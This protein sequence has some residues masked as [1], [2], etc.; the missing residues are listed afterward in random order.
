MTRMRHM[1]LVAGAIAS[2][3]VL[4]VG[5]ASA[6]SIPPR[7]VEIVGNQDLGAPSGEVFYFKQGRIVVHKDDTVTWRNETVAP[8]SITIVSQNDVPHTLAQT[9]EWPLHENFLVA[10]APTIGAEGPIPPFVGSLDGFKASAASPA[11][12]DSNGDSLLVAEMGAGYPSTLGSL[13]PDTVSAV[14]TAPEGTTLSYVCAIHP[15]M[16][17]EIQ[18]LNRFEN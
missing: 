16:N 2:L 14:I 4:T 6:A 11:R 5:Q 13:I 1:I 18:V 12:L 7:T 8:H 3:T 15:W 10:H 17:G 9:L